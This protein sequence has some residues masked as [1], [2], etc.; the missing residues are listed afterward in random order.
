MLFSSKALKALASELDELTSV[1]GS[2]A[3]L[4]IVEGDLSVGCLLV[5]DPSGFVLLEFPLLWGHFDETPILTGIGA[6]SSF[7]LDA[8]ISSESSAEIYRR[9]ITGRAV[10]E[11]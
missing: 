11:N 1:N 4:E 5:D 3:A 8:S 7:D 6:F 10:D 9:V 2:P